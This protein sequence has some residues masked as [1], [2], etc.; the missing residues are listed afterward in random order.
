MASRIATIRKVENSR[1]A[2]IEVVPS[3]AADLDNR[4]LYIN[5]ELSLLTFQRRVLEEAMDRGNPLLERI[6]F[7]SIVG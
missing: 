5:R 7:V 2:E 4:E 6:R 3:S 1:P